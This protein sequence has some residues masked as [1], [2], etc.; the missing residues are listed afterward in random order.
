MSCE[1]EHMK[2]A[3]EI[4]R[5]PDGMLVRLRISCSACNGFAIFP[6]LDAGRST[7]RPMA[8]ADGT[9]A[10]LPIAFGDKLESRCPH[11]DVILFGPHVRRERPAV[12]QCGA[13]HQLLYSDGTEVCVSDSGNWVVSDD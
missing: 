5:G 3:A 6:G 11:C 1:H 13:E 4:E 2:A 10:R 9:E 12:V 8:S 7:E